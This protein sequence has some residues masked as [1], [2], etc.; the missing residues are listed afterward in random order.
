[1][2]LFTNYLTKKGGKKA[3]GTRG[4]VVDKR[5]KRTREVEKSKE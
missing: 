1:M 5:R 3:S 4:G 2:K